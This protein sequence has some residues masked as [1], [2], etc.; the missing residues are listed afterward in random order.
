MWL[1][2]GK[3]TFAYYLNSSIFF[4]LLSMG[5]V[6]ACANSVLSGNLISE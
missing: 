4:D 6:Q 2:F 3:V 1:P 5:A